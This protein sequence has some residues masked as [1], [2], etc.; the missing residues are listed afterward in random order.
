MKT[1]PAIYKGNRL[2]ELCDYVYL[3]EDSA[4]LVVVP[5]GEESEDEAWSKLA[6]NQFFEGYTEADSIYDG[7]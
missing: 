7:L 3:A 5:E 2:L 4:V 6:L 1:F